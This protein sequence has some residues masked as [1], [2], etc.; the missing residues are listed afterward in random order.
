MK[1]TKNEQETSINYNQE[2]DMAQIYTC[3]RNLIRKIDAHIEKNH[4][5]YCIRRDDE[6]ATY[7]LPK[8]FIKFV[9]SRQL[10]E[11]QRQKSALRMKTM[12]A[13]RGEN[14]V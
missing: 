10:T 3:D 9:F 4:V 7:S 14:H 2:E 5:S 12:N 6:S 8:K 11:E 13:Q 1:L